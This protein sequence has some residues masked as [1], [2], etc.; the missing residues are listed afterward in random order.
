[1]PERPPSTDDT[2]V[3]R[4][5][6]PGQGGI[7]VLSLFGPRAPAVLAGLFV[8]PRGADPASVP[9]GRLVYGRL[10]R[11]GETLD[12]V[13]L[14]RVPDPG[15]G[16]LEFEMNCHGGEAPARRVLAALEASGVRVVSWADA[17]QAKRRT[18]GADAVR[19]EAQALL[20]D[21]LTRDAARMLLAQSR[22]ELPRLLRDILEGLGVSAEGAAERIKALLAA[23]RYGLKL[24]APA[25]V[26]VAGRPNVGK[27]A[28]MNA[29][30]RHDRVIVHERPGVTRDVIEEP[31]DVLGLPVILSDMAGVRR[32]ADELEREGVRR[33]LR[34]VEQADVLLLVLD[35]SQPPRPED[36]RLVRATSA[37]P[38]I[39]VLN[40]RDLPAAPS[41]RRMAEEAR[42]CVV[43][44]SALT[45]AGIE[46]LSAGLVD[47][48]AGPAPDLDGPVPFTERQVSL[49]QEAH[50]ALTMASHDE[51]RARRALGEMLHGRETAPERA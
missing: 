44:V 1:M 3:V 41:T 27:S 40:K 16:D 45:G 33:A 13:V 19:A 21:A 24:V 5:T 47:L 6:P 34:A 30:L 9:A 28:L 31:C 14:C 26:G 37:R 11:N 32:A 43:A 35:G 39:L 17:V 50:D 15:S 4:L 46:A 8:S 29:L 38:R 23:A 51:E 2:R 12:E 7:T 18:A 10:V 36:E 22:G 49:L 42:G 20:P 25:G 48:I